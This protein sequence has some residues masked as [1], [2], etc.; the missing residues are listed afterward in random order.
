MIDKISCEDKFLV[1]SDSE[2]GCITILLNLYS[3]LGYDMEDIRKEYDDDSIINR[4]P[5]MNKLKDV[6]NK[7]H[8]IKII[9]DSTTEPD[10][11]FDLNEYDRIIISPKIIYGLDCNKIKR[12]VFCYYKEHTINPYSMIQQI[13][14]NRQIEELNY[15]FVKKKFTQSQYHQI[16]ECRNDINNT[17]NDVINNIIGIEN[18]YNIPH[19]KRLSELYLEL[20]T[21]FK[22]RDDS[23]NTNKFLHFT[24]LLNK[25]GFNLNYEHKK[26][27]KRIF[28]QDEPTDNDIAERFIQDIFDLNS[29]RTYNLNQ[30]LQLADDD[31]LD[32]KELFTNKEYLRNHF[33]ICSY[34]ITSQK[35]RKKNSYEDNFINDIKIQNKKHKVDI[36]SSKEF[37]FHYLNMLLMDTGY[38][39][40]KYIELRK[41]IPNDRIEFYLH[42]L[43]YVYR[44]RGNTEFDFKNKTKVITLIC[45]I[46]KSLFGD[47]IIKKKIREGTKTSNKS[48]LNKSYLNKHFDIYD[49][50]RGK[51][52]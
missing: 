51:G 3:K 22:Y 25:R 16:N 32:N 28:T 30:Y 11:K 39:D 4:I 49:I 12:K 37:K 29:E 43:K 41:D 21:Y 33:N 13:A 31:I 24:M 2:R 40:N 5:L 7:E 34:Y 38:N 47:I 45:S 44:Y 42:N 17:H 48:L 26:N 6:I 20:K 50:G 35:Y 27:T 1:C 46:Y 10:E 18:I 9:T 15:M 36:V 8:Y 23:F 19:N 52:I 14:R